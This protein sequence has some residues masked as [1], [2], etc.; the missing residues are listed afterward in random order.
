MSDQ[1]TKS[2]TPVAEEAAENIA[3]KRVKTSETASTEKKPEVTT[4]GKKPI[5]PHVVAE[6]V[7][8]EDDDFDSKEDGE[9]SF[10]SDFDEA[11][12]GDG[13]DEEI[14]IET[15]KKWRAEHGDEEVPKPE[16]KEESGSDEDDSE[17]DEDEDEWDDSDEE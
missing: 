5:R 6:A 2:T 13:K 16:G 17:D 8:D 11:E 12:S 10:D 3:S 14:D 15:Y 4:A 9:D 1:P 7:D